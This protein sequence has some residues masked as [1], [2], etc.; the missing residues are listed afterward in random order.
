M[1]ANGAKQTKIWVMENGLPTETNLYEFVMESAEQ[2]TSPRG[3]C[4]KL[5]IREIEQDCSCVDDEGCF[6]DDCKKCLH[7][8]ELV[9]QVWDWGFRGQYPQR[10]ETFETEEEAEDF[11]YCRTYDFDFSNDVNRDTRYYNTP[12]DLISEDFELNTETAQSYYAH[13]MKA[14]A[15]KAEREAQ[16]RREVEAKMKRVAELANIYAAM[17]ERVEGESQKETEQRLSRAIG[18][19]IEKAV[20]YKAVAILRTKTN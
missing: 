19:R 20:F 7:G 6:D 11:I 8:C 2:T 13:M 17:V 18:E 1:K 12:I 4:N 10:V 3:V 9:Y 15:I 5:H 16:Y 14:E